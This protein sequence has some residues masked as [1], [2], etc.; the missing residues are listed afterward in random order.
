LGSLHAGTDAGVAEHVD[1]IIAA[2]RLVEGAD[3]VVFSYDQDTGEL[4]ASHMPAEGAYL[5]VPVV[6]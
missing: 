1:A 4:Q 3:Q 6:F 5:L 2:A